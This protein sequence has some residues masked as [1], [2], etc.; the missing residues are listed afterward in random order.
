MQQI[1]L[2]ARLIRSKGVGVYFVTHSPSD[3]PAEVLGQL[4]NRVQHALRAF[5]PDDLEVVRATAETFPTTEHYDVEEELTALGTG[6][7]LITALDLKGRPMPTARDD[8]AAAACRS[9]RRSRRPSS[10]PSWPPR[11]SPR[12]TPPTPTPSRPTSCS[13]RGWAARR[14]PRRSRWRASRTPSRRPSARCAR[15]ARPSGAS[16]GATWPARALAS[17]APAPSTRSCAHLRGAQGPLTRPVQRTFS[18]HSGAIGD[19]GAMRVLVVEDEKRLAA[20]LKKGLEAEGF[21]VDVAL[22]G[23]DGLWMATRAARTTR[24]CST[25]CCPGMNGY[26]VCAALRE[27]SDLDADPHAHREGRRPRRG[28]GARHRRRRLPDQAVLLRRA[29]RAPAGAAAPRRRASARR[30]STPATSAST[31]PRAGSGGATPR[32]T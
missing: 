24:S 30:C 9:W 26:Q 5:T 12:P 13:P 6:E 7:A 19:D 15:P 27:A 2:V 3:V 22:D 29:R 17:R 20:G 25:S 11:R 8:D 14:R 21:A 23:T 10:T 1:E 4:G 31:R 28:R 16:T 18:A 32:S